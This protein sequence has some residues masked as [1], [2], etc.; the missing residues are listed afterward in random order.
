MGS[1]LVASPESARLAALGLL[2]AGIM[3]VTNVFMEVARKKA[4]TGVAL[5]P[6]TF[7]CHIFDTLVFAAAWFWRHGADPRPLIHGADPRGYALCLT[8]DLILL[9][10]A[11]WLFF[12]ALQESAMSRAVPFLAFTSVFLVPTGFLILRE[13]PPLA[14]L[15]GVVLTVVG[16]LLMERRA[17]ADGWLAPFRAVYREKGSRYMLG[18]ALLVA[19]STPLDKKLSLMTD[20]YTQSLIYGAGMSV[21]FYALC[22]T[23][24]EPLRAGVTQGWG[25]IALAGTLDALSLLLQFAAY[26]HVGVV[27]VIAIK[28][29]GIVLSVLFGWWFFH[30]RHIREKLLAAGVMFIGVLMLYVNFSTLCAVEIVVGTLACAGIAARWL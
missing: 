9:G 21:F 6:A 14:K 22:R 16:S 26:R 23:R 13:L 18:V 30:E 3:S 2:V 7:W 11:N 27:L 28:R 10:F 4:V 5:L 12:K 25:W 24:G 15:L 20:I 19:L 8:L 29:S 17:F 1:G